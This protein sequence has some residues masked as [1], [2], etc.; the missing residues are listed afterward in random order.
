MSL[1]EIVTDTR[2]RHLHLPPPATA[3][4]SV[5]VRHA[6]E[7]LREIRFPCLLIVEDGRLVGIFTERDVLNKVIARKELLDRPVREIMTPDPVRIT[8][9]H[10]LD[11]AIRVMSDGGYR[12]LPVV[13]DRGEAVASLSASQIV[14]FIVEHFPQE[15]FNLP[16]RPEQHMSSPEGA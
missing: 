7:M 9:D 6:V 3:E 1:N 11:E 12:N 5:T 14:G 2:I 15:V 16:P 4:S 13:N 10:S 8:P